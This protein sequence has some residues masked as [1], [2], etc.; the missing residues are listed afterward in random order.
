MAKSFFDT[1][2]CQKLKN[3]GKVSAAWDQ[4]NSNISAE[5]LA[6]AGFDVLVID[7]EHAH[8]TLPNVISMIQATKGTECVPFIR[9]PWNDIVWCKQALDTGAYGIHVPYVQTKEETEAAVRYCKYPMQ[10]VRG[11][12]MSHRAI[13]YG[14]NKDDYFPVANRELMVLIA[15]ETPL[16]VENIHE[17]VNVEGVDGIF[18]G[19]A[20]LATSMGH[21][22]NPA[23][24][25]VQEAIRRI[26][27][28]V[29]PTGKFLGTVAPN[30]QAAQKLYDRGY[31]IIYMMSDLGA[32]VKA[33]QAEVK[34]FREAQN[35]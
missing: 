20:D 16:G 31:G 4:M 27:E 23:H 14:M 32:V 35:P 3:G 30:A 8:T 17:I 19:P 5:I 25:E 2:V 7:M 22:A 29:L 10:G 18:I 26:E 12:A 21:L 11:I 1:T 9:V 13:N 24:P 6:E 33:A 28:A 15:I 34:A